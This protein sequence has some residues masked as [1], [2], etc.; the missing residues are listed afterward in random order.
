[1]FHLQQ[2]SYS[3]QNKTNGKKDVGD[4]ANDLKRVIKYIAIE[5]TNTHLLETYRIYITKYSYVVFVVGSQGFCFASYPF[6]NSKVFPGNIDY[7]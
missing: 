3:Y 2:T 6:I 1:M 7:Y 5:I 4:V